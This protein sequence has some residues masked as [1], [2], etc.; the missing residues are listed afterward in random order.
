MP[1]SVPS[2]LLTRG[3]SGEASR[4]TAARLDASAASRVAA[5]RAAAG[6]ARCGV[7]VGGGRGAPACGA[8]SRA[9]TG[10]T[11][12]RDAGAGETLSVEPF[13]TAPGGEAGIAA[14]VDEPPGAGWM[15]ACL[16]PSFLRN[17]GTGTSPL[18]SREAG[19]RGCAAMGDVPGVGDAGV[20][21]CLA[22]R[23]ASTSEKRVLMGECRL[24]RGCGGNVTKSPTRN[25]GEAAM[26]NGERTFR[27]TS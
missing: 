20:D 10:C 2:G 26:S 1:F 27:R 15:S 11:P 7:A 14:G 16:C 13:A 12:F 5:C 4:N 25:V 24:D 18:A 9:D 3:V 23:R 6:A 22:G 19:R 21:F 17:R 8:P